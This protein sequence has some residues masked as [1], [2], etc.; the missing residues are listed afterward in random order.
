MKDKTKKI[1]LA[2]FAVLVLIAQSCSD[3]EH[4]ITR[5]QSAEIKVVGNRLSF[6]SSKSYFET[7]LKVRYMTPDE[8]SE[9]S[10]KY[11]F[12]SLHSLG[13]NVSSEIE[14]LK[15][16]S[17]AYQVILNAN[18]EVLIGDTIVWYAPNNIKH[19]V[20]NRDEEELSKIRTGLARGKITE[21]YSQTLVSKKELEVPEGRFI[22]ANPGHNASDRPYLHEFYITGNSK[23]F[24]YESQLWNAIDGNWYR[25]DLVVK[26][27]WRGADRWK[28]ALE[29]RYVFVNVTG[30]AFLYQGNNSNT[31]VSVYVNQVQS[32]HLWLSLKDVYRSGGTPYWDIVL[33][34]SINQEITTDPST[35]WHMAGPLW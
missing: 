5:P 7:I 16:L 32:G 21:R 22:W 23:K 1:Q 31:Y 34:G 26:L 14:G 19:L 6:P 24:R 2:L 9:F 11:R 13:D 27:E 30:S 18:G 33:N 12:A 10:K 4:V 8:F 17:P 25:L 29:S 3:D 20:P 35:A 15:T 28:E